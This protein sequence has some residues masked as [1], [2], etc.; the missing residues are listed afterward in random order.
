M[1]TLSEVEPCSTLA[2]QSHRLLV[3][4]CCDTPNASYGVHSLSPP[5]P[6]VPPGMRG[7]P[8]PMP[9]PGYGAAPPGPPRPPPFG[10]QRA[11][12]MPPRPPGAPPRVP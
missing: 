4:K 7:P 2:A 8:P 12:P 6:P 11:P 10:F 5:V 1:T 9:P 3:F